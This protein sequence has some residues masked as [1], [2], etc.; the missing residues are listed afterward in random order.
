[1]KVG[2]LYH[3]PLLVAATFVSM[4]FL[5]GDRVI[6]SQDWLACKVLPPPSRRRRGASVAS[7][8][9]RYSLGYCSFA[10]EWNRGRSEAVA[11][12][13][14]FL[15]LV[16]SSGDKSTQS[17]KLRKKGSWVAA[18]TLKLW[19]E[20][21]CLRIWD[22]V[23]GG[24]GWGGFSLPGIWGLRKENRERNRQSI[25]NVAPPESKSLFY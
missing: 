2:T 8:A 19:S 11:G 1:M 7:Y 10:T 14:N 5:S 12:P 24:G 17:G 4:Q 18:A 13:N 25:T 16:R 15:H 21:G 23:R 3:T 22:Y 20:P 6:P 9:P